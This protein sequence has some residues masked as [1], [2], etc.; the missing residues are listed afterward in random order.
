MR[1]QASISSPSPSPAPQVQHPLYAASCAINSVALEVAQ[2]KK[3]S[4]IVYRG[5]SSVALSPLLIVAVLML[6]CTATFAYQREDLGNY[7]VKEFAT[8]ELFQTAYLNTVVYYLPAE[9][10]SSSHSN[11]SLLEPAL[12]LGSER[13]FFLVTDIKDVSGKRQEWLTMEW[14]IHELD[15]D[16]EKT[17]TLISG[18]Y[19]GE[20]YYYEQD[21]KARIKDV[22]FYSLDEWRQDHFSEIGVVFKHPMVKAGYEVTD[23]SLELVR[24]PDEPI[25]ETQFMKF[26]TIRNTITGDQYQYAAS[27]AEALCFKEDLAGEFVSVLSKVEKPTDPSVRYGSTTIVEDE[28]MTKFGYVDDF[29]DIVIYG[30]SNSFC[31]TLKNIT[32][33]TMKL[34]WDDAVFVGCSGSSSRVI[35]KGILFEKME[36]SQPASIIIRGATLVDVAI[37]TSNVFYNDIL[38]EWLVRSMYPKEATTEPLQVQLMLPIQIKEIVNEYIF[39]FDVKYKYNHPERLKLN[40]EDGM[41]K[42]EENPK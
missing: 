22:P 3:F 14:T 18:N 9:R 41:N 30:I 17:V 16:F 36:D 39:V 2:Q 24:V 35:H 21:R 10:A 23:I 4:P 12:D 33:N 40:E 13:R 32:E 26:Y 34:I 6:L 37:P 7:R 42:G 11:Y 19:K 38:N 20:I 15:S 28:G 27:Q 1:S 31:F 25:S 8:V 29:I 5:R